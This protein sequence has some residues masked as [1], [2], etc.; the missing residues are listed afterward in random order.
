[1]SGSKPDLDARKAKFEKTWQQIGTVLKDKVSAIR[2][3]FD[4]RFMLR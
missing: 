2:S 3:I 1:M 4:I